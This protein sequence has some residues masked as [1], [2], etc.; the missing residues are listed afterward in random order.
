M[1]A[2]P[3]LMEGVRWCVG[4]GKSIK[5]WGD[6]WIPSAK[7]GKI[8]S[9]RLVMDIGEKVANLIAHDKAEWNVGLVRSIFLP[10]EAETILSILLAP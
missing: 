10:L 6:A 4:D 3:V 7:S 5:I 8:I 2:K 1:A 9:P